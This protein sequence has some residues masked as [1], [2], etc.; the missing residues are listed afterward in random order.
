MTLDYDELGDILAWGMLDKFS[1][2]QA[3]A[4]RDDGHEVRCCPY[5]SQYLPKPLREALADG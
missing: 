3:F 4:P 1:C 5:D 2:L